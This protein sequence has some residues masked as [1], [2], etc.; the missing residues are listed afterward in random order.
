MAPRSS[1][2]LRDDDKGQ[3]IS[4][5]KEKEEDRIGDGSAFKRGPCVK[6]QTIS[7]EAEKEEDREGAEE[8]VGNFSNSSFSSY[9]L[10]KRK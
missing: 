8:A 9:F 4:R 10:F 7:R 3:T 1:R 6:G 5:K 2:P